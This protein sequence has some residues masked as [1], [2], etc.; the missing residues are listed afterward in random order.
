MVLADTPWIG[1]DVPDCVAAHE[2]NLAECAV[3]REVA[4][5]RSAG[6][7]QRDAVARESRA[8]IID[9]TDWVC[10]AEECAPVIGD[11]LVWR[12][13]HHLTAT[14]ALSLQEM[15]DDSLSPIITNR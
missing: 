15:L 4:F 5:A 7:I 1:L 3:S 8:H 10:P 9:V 11:V 14:Y 13:A 6:S 12:D 2:D